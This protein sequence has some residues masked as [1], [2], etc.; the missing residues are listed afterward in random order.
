M[1]VAFRLALVVACGVLAAQIA[2]AKPK[3]VANGCTTEQIQSAAAAPCP[4]KRN[5]D[6]L[7]NRPTHHALHCSSTGKLLC[8]EYHQ[9]GNTVDPSCS[10]IGLHSGGPGHRP[11][12]A[13]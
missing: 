13:S 1:R 2:D 3:K 5:D 10:V 12:A 8:C 11:A 6:V 9:A 4:D 7:H